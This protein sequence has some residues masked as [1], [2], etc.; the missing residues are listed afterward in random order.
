VHDFRYAIRGL[1]RA[2]GFALAAI[3]TLALGIGAVT[4]I[5]SVA[6]AVLLRPLPYPESARVVVV[7]EQGPT[8]ESIRSRAAIRERSNR[9][10]RL[11]PHTPDSAPLG[12]RVKD[13]DTPSGPFVTVVSDT[14]TRGF[15]PQGD[16]IGH[17]ILMGAPRPDSKWLTIV[18]IVGDVKAAA[19]DQPALPHFYTPMSQH[20]DIYMELAIR[21]SV[22]PISIARQAADVVRSVDSEAPAFGVQT[23]EQRVARSV[24]QPRFESSVLGFFAAAALFLA[25]IGIF[26]VVAHST[27]RRTQEIGIRVALGAD[28]A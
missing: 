17:R 8:V 11:F 10:R 3:L 7:W 16:A 2:P 15:F 12:P 5:F 26:G 24:S 28:R 18:G 22:D 4:S 9:R 1:L 27:M 6:N 13:T 25:A 20:P 21:T 23:M 14:L 19:L